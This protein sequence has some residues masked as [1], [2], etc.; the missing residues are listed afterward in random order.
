M[1]RVRKHLQNGKGNRLCHRK[2]AAHGGGF[3][4]GT[5]LMAGSKGGNLWAGFHK[6]GTPL[7]R[8]LKGWKPLPEHCDGGESGVLGDGFGVPSA[9]NIACDV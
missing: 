3:R 8:G 7:C 2:A 6:G 4:G 1:P 5:S 9:R